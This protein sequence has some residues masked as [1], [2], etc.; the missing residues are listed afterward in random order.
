[1]RINGKSNSGSEVLLGTD[2]DDM[3]YPLGGSDFVD[4]K[5]GFDS[6]EVL[7]PSTNFRITTIEGTTYLDAISGA[8]SADRVTI[9]HVE[10]VT[11]SDASI[12]LEIPDV[13]R[14]TPA[15]DRFD[16]GPG[17]DSVIF[18]GESSSYLIQ[19]QIAGIS[20]SPRSRASGADWLQDIERLIFSD[21]SLAF[22]TQGSAGATLRIL[23]AVFGS[24]AIRNPAYVGIGI[25]V[26][27]RKVYDELTLLGLALQSRLGSDWDDPTALVELLYSN[28]TGQ[29]PSPSEQLTYENLLVNGDYTPLS[30]AQAVADSGLNSQKVGLMASPFMGVSYVLPSFLDVS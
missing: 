4:A 16:G 21:V 20:I 9:R 27:D 30:L 3:I 25:D 8:S 17:V 26:L 23:G 5:G 12:S 18:G 22:D 10:Q 19:P 1:M 15:A 11:F 6:L 2:G 14:D 29:M 7:W 24:E 13:L 28:L